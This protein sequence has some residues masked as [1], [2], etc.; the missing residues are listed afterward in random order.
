VTITVSGTMVNTPSLGSLDP[1]YVLDSPPTPAPEWLRYNR[2]SEGSCL[3]GFECPATSHRVSDILV[4]AYPPFESSHTYTVVLDLGSAPPE[5]LHFSIYDCGCFDNSGTFTVTV[6]E[7]PSCEDDD[8]DGVPDYL[9]ACPSSA[10]VPVDARGC[11][12]AQFCHAIDATTPRGRRVCNKSDWQNDEPLMTPPDWDCRVARNGPGREDDQCEPTDLPSTTTTTISAT[13]TTTAPSVA[14]TCD[15]DGAPC[16]V[17]SDC[18]VGGVCDNLSGTA[19]CTQTCTTSADCINGMFCF[20]FQHPLGGVC[21]GCQGNDALCTGDAICHD[22]QG[23]PGD[24]CSS[25]GLTE[26][27]GQTTLTPCTLAGRCVY[28]P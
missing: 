8:G 15:A 20:T 19:T 27:V 10:A 5:P 13:T 22:S 1:F 23:N 21:A 7:P 17:D 6:P 12:V 2:V 16:A 25:H 18:D 26:C 3:C 4:G 28:D 14:G 24:N 9:D 11:T